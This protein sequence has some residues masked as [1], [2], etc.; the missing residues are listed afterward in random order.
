LNAV[1]AERHHHPARH[2]PWYREPWPW[3]IMSGPAI[4]VVAGITTAVIAFRTADG[5]V[6]DDYYK[7]GLMINKQIARDDAART[8]GIEGEVRLA[9]GIV[10]VTL[11]SAAALPDR[12]TLR[13]VHPSRASEDRIVHLARQADAEYEAPLPALA[14]AHWLAIV[15]TPQWR[16][17]ALVDPRTQ[18]S[19]ALTPGAS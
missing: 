2:K 19:A 18:S 1:T 14:P 4:V 17:S 13:L 15:E 6:A 8:L 16:V 12:L 5:L 9:P 10:R 7:Q 3:L 11:R